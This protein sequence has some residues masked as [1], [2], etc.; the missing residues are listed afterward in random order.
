MLQFQL[1]EA[2]SSTMIEIE[3]RKSL[4]RCIAK[5]GKRHSSIEIGIR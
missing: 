4:T 2:Q 1:G 3:G 5:F